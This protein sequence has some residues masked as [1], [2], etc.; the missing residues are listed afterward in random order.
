MARGNGTMGMSSWSGSRWAYEKRKKKEPPTLWKCEGESRSTSGRRVPKNPTVSP[1]QGKGKELKST[2]NGT[3]GAKL[4][5]YLRRVKKGG[6]T[7]RGQKAPGKV[8]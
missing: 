6:Q 4:K 5:P 3:P 7:N 2:S 8:G 1:T